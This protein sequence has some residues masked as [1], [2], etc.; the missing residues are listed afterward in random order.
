MRILQKPENILQINSIY[1]RRSQILAADLD[2]YAADN[3]CPHLRETA[4]SIKGLAG[5]LAANAAFE[6]A[7]D[8][9]NLSRDGKLNEACSHIPDLKRIL[10]EISEDLAVLTSE[11]NK[12]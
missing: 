5:M 3:D 8:L 9:E 12:N 4:H 10:Q 6:L 7:R 2:K 11:I 1:Q